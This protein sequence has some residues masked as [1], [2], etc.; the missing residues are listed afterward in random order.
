M[1]YQSVG[2]Y[3]GAKVAIVLL[4]DIQKYIGIT[5]L[6]IGNVWSSIQCF[7][8]WIRLRNENIA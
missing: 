4:F 6:S 7:S 3:R 5:A 8:V 1:C 2:G